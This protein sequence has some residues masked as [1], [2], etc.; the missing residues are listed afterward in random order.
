M[1]QFLIRIG[2]WRSARTWWRIAALQDGENAGITLI[3]PD[4]APPLRS[5]PPDGCGAP[6]IG[7]AMVRTTGIPLQS[8]EILLAIR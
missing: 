1:I 2:Q 8:I 7:K 3:R 4:H 6:A 5:A